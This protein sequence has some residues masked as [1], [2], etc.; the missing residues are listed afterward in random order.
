MHLLRIFIIGAAMVGCAIIGVAQT[1]EPTVI[2]V[3]QPSEPTPA[4]TPTAP[5]T[6]AAA[7]PAEAAKE[8]VETA[9]NIK[10]LQEL[11][12][13]NDEILKQQQAAL[14]QLDQLQKEAEQLRVF[15]KRG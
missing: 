6:A 7:A 5:T 2:G 13:Q 11:K 4:T 3:P 8:Q 9:A 15:S 10:E 12:V 14:D 1:S